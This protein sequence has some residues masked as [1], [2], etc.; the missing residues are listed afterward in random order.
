MSEPIRVLH[1]LQRM[2]LAG[3]Q[4]L[5]MNVYRKIDRTKVQFDFLV[6]Y[7]EPQFFDKEIKE[8]GGRIYRLSIREDYNLFKY[9]LD[10]NIF[11]K[12]HTE[13][14]IVHGH[15]HSLGAIYLHIAKKCGVK[16]RIAHSHTNSTQKDVKRLLKVIM[17]HL[18][19]LEATDLFACSQSA[20]KYMFGSK[21]FRV[22]NNAII[23]DIFLFSAEKRKQKRKELGIADE[24]VIGCIGRFEDKSQSNF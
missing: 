20:G 14:Q 22:I 9:Y 3:V 24:F 16:V 1:V 13:Y 19:S 23:T 6:H 18:Y 8:L 4:T 7:T 11:F 17:N 2:E 5:L 10:L 21:K 12:E 15:M